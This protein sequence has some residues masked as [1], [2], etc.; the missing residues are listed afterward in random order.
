[1]K[2]IKENR[3]LLACIFLMLAFFLIIGELAFGSPGTWNKRLVYSYPGGDSAFWRIYDVMGDSLRDSIA[4]SLPADTTIS[5]STDSMYEIDMGYNKTI[6]TSAWYYAPPAP[7]MP[8][9]GYI[10]D[11]SVLNLGGL[12]IN[13]GDS[14]T[15]AFKVYNAEGPGTIFQS[16]GDGDFAYGFA[17]LAFMGAANYSWSDSGQAQRWGSKGDYTWFLYNSGDTDQTH[18]LGEAAR[19]STPS[20][21]GAGDVWVIVAGGTDTTRKNYAVEWE[22]KWY[23]HGRDNRNETAVQLIGANE[24]YGLYALSQS[25]HGVRFSSQ[26]GS[27]Y[28][29]LYVANGMRVDDSLYSPII[30]GVIAQTDTGAILI[31]GQNHPDV[32]YGPSATG[33]GSEAWQLVAYDSSN[34]QPVPLSKFTIVPIGGGDKIVNTTH[35]GGKLN[36]LVDL[37]T[38]EVSLTYPGMCFDRDTVV[39]TS[40]GQIDTV[41]GY[42]IASTIPIP[43]QSTMTTVFLIYYRNGTAQPGVYLNVCNYNV[44]QDTVNQAIIGPISEAAKTNSNGIAYTE[45]PKS[46]VFSDS[47]KS[48]YDIYIRYRGKIIYEWEDL[49]IPDVDTFRLTI[50]D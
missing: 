26:G 7:I 43:S 37:D 39:V 25:L 41:T 15:A 40:D 1:L 24:G 13:G 2:F 20:V 10:A 29:G 3:W 22:G 33:T 16:S 45:V 21:P 36:V 14:I 27:N 48:L 19:W 46:Y 5:L 4:A 47:L 31:L 49:Y 9:A 50:Q 34:S 42:A 32:Y 44:S 28:T 8:Y 6:D 30:R 17:Q 11:S 18:K 35:E 38:F 12:Y 23:A